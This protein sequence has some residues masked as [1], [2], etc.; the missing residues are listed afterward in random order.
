MKSSPDGTVRAFATLR[1]AGDQLVPHEITDIL[2][3][4][5]TLSYRKGE[6]YVGGKNSGEISGR[7]GVWYLS[8]DK[9][10]SSNTLSDHIIYLTGILIPERTLGITNPPIVIGPD[11][12]LGKTFHRLGKLQN[13]IQKRDLKATMSLF[14]HGVAGTRLPSIPK[15][16]PP[17]F[18]LVPIG[19]EQDFDTDGVSQRDAA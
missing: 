3:A 2:R 15:A 18:R 1:V 4:Y 9:I 10:V 13:I 11:E 6:K 5:P 8:T 12:S 7:T 14:W 16:I 19:I 17:L